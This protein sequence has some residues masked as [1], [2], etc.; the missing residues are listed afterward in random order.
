MNNHIPTDSPEKSSRK[1]GKLPLQSKNSQFSKDTK[2]T[3]THYQPSKELNMHLSCPVLL[4]ERLADTL[5][6]TFGALHRGK[7]S[8]ESNAVLLYSKHHKSSTK[9]K[10]FQYIFEKNARYM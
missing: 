8:P 5:P 1:R 6:Y 4:P 2:R 10:G 9:R 3:D 7:D